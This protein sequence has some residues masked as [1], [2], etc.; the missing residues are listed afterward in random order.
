[1]ENKKNI[2]VIGSS[3]HQK[4]TKCIQWGEQEYVGDYDVLIINTSS[5]T[6]ELLETIIQKT[7]NYFSRLKQNISDT[8]K[9]RGIEIIC[10]LSSHVF[11]DNVDK[12]RTTEDILKNTTNNYSWSPVI[13]ILEKIPS[14]KK[15]KIESSC[16][17]EEYL[18]GIKEYNLLSNGNINN[19]GYVDENK[20]AYIYTKL[21]YSPLLKNDIGRDIAF[22]IT[23]KLHQHSEYTTLADGKLPIIFLPR[24]EN[25]KKGI[26]IL[27]SDLHATLDEEVPDWIDEIILP[28]EKQIR[29]NIDTKIQK[30]D[31]INTEIQNEKIKLDNLVKYKSLL[32]SKGLELEKITEESFKLLGID[33]KSPTIKNMEDRYH[34]T[35]DG[36]KIYFEIRGVNRL[37]NEGDVTQ[38]IKR[39]AEKNRSKDYNTR[40]VFV[41]NHQ[42]KKNPSNRDDA[43]HNNIENQ[44][45]SF[46]ICLIDTKKLFELVSKKLNGETINNFDKKIFNTIGIFK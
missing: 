25:I 3:E 30:T 10:I 32:Y 11:N 31:L 7:P 19:T 9:N 21:Y 5:L 6:K 34:E 37:M 42:N 18:K 40:G 45:K 8:Q 16:I 22:K 44:A 2:L 38:L 27:L 20:Q 33:L 41:F 26:D 43:F 4:A 35:S 15:I 39:I 14:A 1:M 46:N 28:G 23:W 12:N 24:T 29:N 17:S 13:P 36:Q